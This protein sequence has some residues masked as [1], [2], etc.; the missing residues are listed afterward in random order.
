MWTPPADEVVKDTGW[1]PPA[2]ERIDQSVPTLRDRAQSLL[3]RAAPIAAKV[4]AYAASP[5][6]AVSD[7]VSWAAENPRQAY[8]KAGPWLPAAG[9]TA[10]SAIAPGLGTAIGGGV[11]EI[12]RQGLGVAFQDPKVMQHITP[13]QPSV[14]SG[15]QA[16]LQ[17]GAAG[18]NEVNGLVKAAPGAAPYVQRGIEA[19]SDALAPY[20]RKLVNAGAAVGQMLTGKPAAKFKMLFKDPSAA[21]PESLGGAKSVESAGKGM[22]DALAQTGIQKK[23]FNPFEGET[24]PNQIASQ[25]YEKWKAGEDA[26]QPAEISAQEAYNAKRA[27]DYVF[28]KVISERNREKIATMASFKNAM[29]DILGNQAGPLQA[30][31]KDYARA[32]L[33]SDFTQILPRTKTGD[34]STV[35]TMFGALLDAKR[36]AALPLTSPI[37]AGGITSL[38]S[39]GSNLAGRLITNP[40]TR[41]A[42]ISRLITSTSSGQK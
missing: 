3:E 30:A 2:D 32:R 1:T 5:A 24:E 26:G 16:A 42:L 18:L 10:G 29:D 15:A 40:T 14:W 36:A 38:A 11:G 28:P 7:A 8:E 37:V 19:A 33:G 20:G 27:T 4:G 13:G 9:A 6:S 22:E 31:S 23:T 39:A 34:I 41:Q 17:T 21:L 25:T 12:A 35:K